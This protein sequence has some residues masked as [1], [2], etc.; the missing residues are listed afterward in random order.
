MNAPDTN[1]RV[2]S[3]RPTVCYMCSSECGL[4]ASGDPSAGLCIAGNPASPMSRG[5]LCPK[6]ALAESLR[7]FPGRPCTPLKRVGPR[8]E[9]I[10][11]PASWEEALEDISRRLRAARELYGPE[12]LTILF[13][14]KPDHD[15][16][17]DFAAMYGTPNV[18]DH[19]SLCD[20]SRRY[21]FSRV[22]GDGQERPLPD[23]QRPLL[24]GEGVRREHDC[25]LLVLFGENPA[26]ARRF[27]W[28][29]DG[30]LGARRSGMR[31]IVA[32][33]LRTPAEIGRAH[34]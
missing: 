24:T 22:F 25:R 9:G 15:M 3:P 4:L 5:G 13:G 33:P 10:F 2:Q 11:R 34:V 27:F 8:G 23:L 32:D 19:N 18:L 7:C 28:L 21:G 1:K 26:E 6:A 12:S 31:L 20:T 17:Y 30:I 29:W 14:E 16:V